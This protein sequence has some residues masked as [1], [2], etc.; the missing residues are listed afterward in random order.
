MILSGAKP[1][2]QFQRCPHRRW[3]SVTGCVDAAIFSSQH[4]A[5]FGLDTTTISEDQAKPNAVTATESPGRR[6]GALAISSSS[7]FF[8]KRVATNSSLSNVRSANSP[9][10]TL[11]NLEPSPLLRI[12]VESLD[13]ILCHGVAPSLESMCCCSA[14][15]TT[16]RADIGLRCC[17]K[18][19]S[20]T[21]RYVLCT[22]FICHP[23]T[24]N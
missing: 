18:S 4:E 21:S 1:R 8:R 7:L 13:F 22:G 14:S 17:V 15:E 20:A 19:C 3:C 24:C 11:L 23:F 10:D 9:C 12:S 6:S 16:S 2:R 5:P